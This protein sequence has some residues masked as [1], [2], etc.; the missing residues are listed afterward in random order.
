MGER[1]W[2]ET[3]KYF[4]KADFLFLVVEGEKMHSQR[5]QL[6]KCQVVVGASANTLILF[7]SCKG[8]R[9]W[10]ERLNWRRNH[11]I[12]GVVRF[13]RQ[14]ATSC[15]PTKPL[16]PIFCRKCRSS[17]SFIKFWRQNK[18]DGDGGSYLEAIVRV[19]WG[20]GRYGRCRKKFHGRIL[21]L[22]CALTDASMQKLL[23]Q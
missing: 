21:L 23:F 22:L 1:L 8:A 15:Q 11:E 13:H 20:A 7:N 14:G 16:A 3:W 10:A 19:M 18:M 2:T 6:G 4:C 12:P 17:L 9:L 5:S